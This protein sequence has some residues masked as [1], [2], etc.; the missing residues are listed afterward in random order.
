[1]RIGYSSAAAGDC[2]VYNCY[3]ESRRQ[4]GEVGRERR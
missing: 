2:G 4:Y 1:M 3:V